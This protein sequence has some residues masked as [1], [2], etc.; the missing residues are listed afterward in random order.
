MLY[1]SFK[2]IFFQNIKVASATYC[3]FFEFSIGGEPK[4]ISLIATGA[5][6]A[7]M[8]QYKAIFI[9]SMIV[10][11]YFLHGQKRSQMMKELW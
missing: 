6:Y 11:Y 2:S 7:H 5:G 10:V 4:L 1:N 9:L 8:Y 3:S